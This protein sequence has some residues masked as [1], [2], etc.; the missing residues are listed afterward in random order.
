MGLE[1]SEG[2]LPEGELP[3]GWA[4]AS[5]DELF[6]EI[7]NG[8]TKNQNKDGRGIPVTRIE[9]IQRSQFDKTRLGFIDAELSEIGE[10]YQYLKGDIAL[11]HIN[12][13]EHVG[14]T[15]IYN[16]FPSPLIHGMNLLRLRLGHNEVDPKCIFLEM[17]GGKFRDEVRHKSNQAVN[18]VSLNQK[19]LKTIKLSLPP[20]A[21]QKRIVEAVE[22][23][24]SE[25]NTTREALARVPKILKR[26]R[27]SVL[28]AACSGKLTEGWRNGDARWGVKRLDD[29]FLV[30]SGEAFKKKDYSETGTRLLQIA[31][32]GFGEIIWQQQHFVPTKFANQFEDDLL[33]TNDI[34]IALNRPIL[35]NQMKVGFV[36]TKDLPAILYQRVAMLRKAGS[37]IEPRFA[38]T[39]FQSD[40]FR[41]LVQSNLQGSDQPYLNFSLLREFEIPIPPIPEQHEIVRRVDEL[42]AWADDIEAAVTA[43][44]ARAD[45]LTQAILARAFK[46]ELVPTEAELARK[47][48]RDYEPASVLLARIKAERATEAPAKKRGRAMRAATA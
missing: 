25:V 4:E 12:S 11:S 39:Y 30:R 13:L 31:N 6:L 3:E 10:K 8:T 44:T 34:V 45:K 38:F 29:L 22:R 36:T 20:L 23:L 21:E 37:E 19:N 17:Q 40:E 43:A 7:L 27:Q 16:E 5:V 33:R 14:K 1:M 46:G 48:G 47:E 15:A 2:V 26:F 32:V 28:A 9:S 35:G 24:L 18:Q 41:E 42:F